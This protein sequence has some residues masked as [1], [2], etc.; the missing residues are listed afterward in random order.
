MIVLHKKSLK[1]VIWIHPF[2]ECPVSFWNNPG[3]GNTLNP[4][5]VIPFFKKYLGERVKFAFIAVA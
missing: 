4:S 1:Y 5:R 3:T 2:P